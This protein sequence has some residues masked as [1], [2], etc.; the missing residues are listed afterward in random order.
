MYAPL[1]NYLWHFYGRE[2]QPKY[3]EDGIP[4]YDEGSRISQERVKRLLGFDGQPPTKD[5]HHGMGTERSLE[6]YLQFAGI[7]TVNMKTTTQEKF[8]VDDD[9][10]I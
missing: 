1:H 4:G 5:Y 8:C 6:K 7:D 2:N 9:V 10:G 3:W